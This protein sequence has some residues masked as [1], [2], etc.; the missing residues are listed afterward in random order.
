MGFEHVWIYREVELLTLSTGLMRFWLSTELPGGAGVVRR[1][2]HAF[3]TNNQ[4][5]PIRLQFR[6]PM[7]GRITQALIEGESTCRLF[8]ARILA[9][10]LGTADA[11]QWYALPVKVTPEG[12]ATSGLPIRETPE[13]WAASGLPIRET[14]EGWATT[15]LPIPATPEG[16]GAS[17]LPF[18]PAGVEWGW[19]ELPLDA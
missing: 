4:T 17:A 2:E 14:P 3:T 12:W 7:K 9:K 19:R 1:S 11:W 10:R 5:I 18:A 6:A 16:F 15:G 8:G 13:G